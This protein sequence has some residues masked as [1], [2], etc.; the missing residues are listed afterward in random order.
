MKQNNLSQVILMCCYVK[1]QVH[2]FQVNQP[3]LSLLMA[4]TWVDIAAGSLPLSHKSITICQQ[5]DLIMRLFLLSTDFQFMKRLEISL[6]ISREE[7]IL[8]N[9]VFSL[10]RSIQLEFSLIIQILTTLHTSSISKQ[11]NDRHH[12]WT[13]K[14]SC[15][16]LLFFFWSWLSQYIFTFR[17]QKELKKLTKL[18]LELIL[19]LIK[20]KEENPKCKI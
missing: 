1:Q 11:N 12:N 7:I 8:T 16:T 14:P 2:L 10:C 15:L 20:T 3:F 5:L 18:W 9:L 19:N 13:L 4:I 17:K 6:W